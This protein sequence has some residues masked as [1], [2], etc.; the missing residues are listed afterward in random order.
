MNQKNIWIGVGVASGIALA[1]LCLYMPYQLETA[2]AQSYLGW[3]TTQPRPFEFPQPEP[4]TVDEHVMTLLPTLIAEDRVVRK[5]GLEAL[6]M[7]LAKGADTELSQEMREDVARA[8]VDVYEEA[9]EKEH[10][11][12]DTAIR[13]LF[14][15]IQGATA[16]HFALEGLASADI[17]R[18]TAILEAIT[19]PGALRDKEVFNKAFE[20]AQMETTPGK[21]K[22]PVY[23]R[24]LS[25]KAASRELMAL[26]ETDIDRATVKSL[27]VEVQN[28]HRPELL[29][30]VIAK[31][32]KT[33]L[34]ADKKHLPWFSGKLLGKHV[35]QSD[36][37]E[38]I[39]ALRVVWLRP[40]LTR[41]TM[42]SVEARLQHA[43]PTIRR[44][45]A[46]L[47]PDA[48]KYDGMQAV[49]G[50]E[51]LS[52]RLAVETDPAVKGEIEDSL[53]Q[54]RETRR[55]GTA[56]QDTLETSP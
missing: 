52:A 51:V 12:R 39:R 11:I 34:L 13:L 18:R 22:P 17:Q 32:E 36:G 27:A 50:E 15:K 54:V 31:L 44:V 42:K 19:L 9:Q 1:G 56:P 4:M 46:R 5:T 16:K 24:V 10:T 7:T 14:V 43:D 8:L 53:T 55:T 2:P 3:A 33:G 38:L 28:L 20:T 40:A 47:I 26:L 23:R 6:S 30:P 35:E 37:A 25:R 48:V 41:H 49:L 21:L 45:V 29:G